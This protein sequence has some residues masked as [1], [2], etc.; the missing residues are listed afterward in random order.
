[1]F[2]FVKVYFKILII[3]A[4][5]LHNHYLNFDTFVDPGPS[6]LTRSFYGSTR[7]EWS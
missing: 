7:V 5:F 6:P 2:V 1:M 4:E 3:S